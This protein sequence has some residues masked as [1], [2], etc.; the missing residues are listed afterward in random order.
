MN[1]ENTITTLQN[2][3]FSEDKPPSLKP[4]DIALVVYLLLRQTD[5]H[6]IFDSQLTLAERLGCRREAIK[7]SIERL[8]SLEWITTER[9]VKWNPK[10]HNK[11]RTIGKTLGLALNL[12]KLPTQ[13]DRSRHLKPSAEAKWL[14]G[15]HTA[16]LTKNGLI[17]NPPKSFY[18]QQE[19]AA[20]RLIEAIGSA[21]AAVGLF[22][23]ALTD[24]RFE[25]A[26][27]KSL[28][29]VRTRLKSIQQAM[30]DERPETAEV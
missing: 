18:R 26:A 16:I 30:A 14:A 9:A 25:K 5:D 21:K 20:Q 19:H 4:I 8:Q 17:A 11:T 3:L 10:T 15:E 29:E 24:A 6:F 22:N 13:K 28:Y 27:K 12:D 23:F 7:D 1:H 2:L